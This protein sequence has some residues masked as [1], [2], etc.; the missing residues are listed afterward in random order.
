MSLPAPRPLARRG[1]RGSLTLKTL[2]LMAVAAC[3]ILLWC[4]AVPR[5][6]DA[7]GAL[8]PLAA[9]ERQVDARVT[10]CPS[11]DAG[12]PCRIEYRTMAGA[13]ASADLVR[14]GLF[15]VREGDELPARVRGDQAA[16][17]GWR[18]VADAALLLALSLVFTG[19]AVGRWRIVLE[20]GD[21]P[22]T[23]D[24]LDEPG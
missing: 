17:A 24:D 19:Y 11:G 21:V 2:A 23:P 14:V 3:A 16:V 5:V 9:G 7:V 12:A 15:D 6:G 10:T 1:P 13:T 22:W 20:H 8:G 18:P 4:F